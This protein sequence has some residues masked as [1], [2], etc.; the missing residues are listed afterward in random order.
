MYLHTKRTTKICQYYSLANSAFFCSV[1]VF[2]YQLEGKTWIQLGNRSS[3]TKHLNPCTES[4]SLLPVTCTAKTA[5]ALMLT[6]C[7]R[8]ASPRERVLLRHSSSMFALWRK[9]WIEQ[10]L[11][12][13]SR[14]S[15]DYTVSYAIN[16]WALWE[17]DC[18][19]WLHHLNTLHKQ[20]LPHTSGG[21]P[22]DN[23]TKNLSTDG[24]Q[25]F[26]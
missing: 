9:L 25:H 8:T 21:E 4:M 2:T 26:F 10:E 12:G 3:Q 18:L 13:Y 1:S 23:G 5:L 22:V 16:W 7:T 11:V 24:T 15:V 19:Y 6:Y 20:C 17:S 14:S